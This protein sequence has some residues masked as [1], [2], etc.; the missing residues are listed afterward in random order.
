MVLKNK[1]SKITIFWAAYLII[2]PIFMRPALNFILEF[3]GNSG[4]TIMLW[5]LFLFGGCVASSYLYKSHLAGWRIFLFLGIFAA[6]LF[7]ASQVKIVEERMHLINFGLLGWLIIKDISRFKKGIMSIGLSLLFCIF[8]ATIEETLQLWIPNRVA[9]IHDV[10][11]A[12]MGG[13][14]GI[15][16]F[17]SSHP[18]YKRCDIFESDY[19]VVARDRGV[20]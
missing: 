20:F 18:Q 15:S 13:V 10:L 11:L 2:S 9:Q 14:W 8:V 19:N 1:L 5:V 6:G 4:L 12:V 3:L 16:L 17:F 7:Y